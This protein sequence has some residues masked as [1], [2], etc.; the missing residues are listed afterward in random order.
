MAARDASHA[1]SWYSD[2]RD[3]LNQE[4]KKWLDAVDRVPPRSILSQSTG[5]GG[6]FGR[7]RAVIAPHAGY[8]YSGPTAAFAYQFLDVEN[9][10][11]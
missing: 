10:Y 3:Q 1:G 9:M 7:V 11:D 6:H 8:A 4:L 5:S 2:D